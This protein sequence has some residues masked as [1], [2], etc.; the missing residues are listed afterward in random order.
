MP[1]AGSQIVS[2]PRRS[3]R[4]P[5]YGQ[6]AMVVS[7]HSAAT[8]AGARVLDGGGHIVDAMIAASAALAVVLGH[9]TS[10]GGDCFVL[11][12]EAATGKTHALNA[13]GTAPALATP[14]RF[15]DGM[16]AHGPLAPVVPG[17]VRAWDVL[18]K[19]FGRRPWG[20]LFTDAIDLADA[21]TVS[22]ILATRIE[23]HRKE[24]SADPGCAALYLPNGKA[25]AVGDTL[26]QPALASTLR[27]V[28]DK[29]ADA[30]YRG[31]IA[32][33]IDAYFREHQGVMR[34]EDLAGYAPLWVEPIAAEYRG[35]RVTVMPPNSYGGLLLMQLTGLG[36]VDG[37]ALAGD[38]AR[39]IAYQMSAMKMA[40]HLGVPL[41]G[42]PGKNPDSATRM[43]S[44][45]TTARMRAAVVNLESA[46][47]VRDSSGTSCLMLA[48]RAGNAICV[49][50]SVFNVFGS[51]FLEPRTGLL[52]NNRMQGFT[53]Q[54]GRANT[55]IPGTRPAHTLCPV[56]VFRQ[57]RVRFAMASPGGLSQTLTNAQ[58]LTYL[59]DGRM[60]VAAAVEAPRWCNTRSGDFLVEAEFP[61]SVLAAL[62]EAGHKAKR[63][64]DG[65][66][67]GSAKVIE[68]LASGNLAGAADHRREAF[69]LGI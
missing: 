64:D 52:F 48:D 47:P 68:L 19:R 16:K 29:G 7:G 67:Y 56:L 1:E 46:P 3:C 60:D 21:H 54:P 18:H 32:R 36:A 34:A 23:A 42:D 8:L 59:L 65:Y 26:R 45:E 62:A 53:P 11:Y 49:V 27:A 22:H 37:A 5:V 43:L 31:D 15:P 28:A 57:G 55:L 2:E 33:H 24:L 66:F 17:L 6:R 50:Q 69:A 4:A 10:L 30:F 51:A 9:A 39:R 12:H 13:S 41:I 61:E 58:V 20:D 63:R 38:P 44:A 35:H 40:F 14:D 25:L